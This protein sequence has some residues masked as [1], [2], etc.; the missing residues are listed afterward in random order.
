MCEVAVNWT[1]PADFLWIFFIFF[2]GCPLSRFSC[3]VRPFRLENEFAWLQV[4][5][6]VFLF[7]FLFWDHRRHSLSCSGFKIYSKKIT[8]SDFKIIQLIQWNGYKSG[9]ELLWCISCAVPSSWL[10]LSSFSWLQ[11]RQQQRV[12]VFFSDLLRYWSQPL[13]LNSTW[14]R[15]SPKSES[16]LARLVHTKYQIPRRLTQGI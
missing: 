4:I 14:S 10:S 16:N 2:C 5:Y 15:L 7:E 9:Y 6:Q 12:S 3:S 11:T 8:K 1:S 13:Y